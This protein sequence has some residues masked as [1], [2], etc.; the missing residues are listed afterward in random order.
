MLQVC[1]DR[2]TAL[3]TPP[4]HR[5]DDLESLGYVILSLLRQDSSS[6]L[7]WSGAKSVADG[8]AKKRKTSLETLCEGCPAPMLDYMRA[9]RAMEYEDAPEYSSLD[10]MFAEMQEAGEER[11]SG[12][13]K[14]GAAVAK[15]G[16]RRIAKISGNEDGNEDGEEEK[17]PRKL[18]GG[19]SSAVSSEHPQR[20]RSSRLSMSPEKKTDDSRTTMLSPSGKGEEKASRSR[21][22]RSMRS[23]KHE[24]AD[25]AIDSDEDGD[26]E[27]KVVGGAAGKGGGMRRSGR[28][29]SAEAITGVEGGRGSKRGSRRASPPKEFVLEVGI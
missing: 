15:R 7:P 28:A 9:V 19:V 4:P 26:E 20:R 25:S 29:M 24:Q 13:V 11:G 18:R 8:L 12:S 1:S 14:S 27:V 10:A 22:G 2:W 17:G 16:N 6:P 5:C 3:V 21:S 23:L